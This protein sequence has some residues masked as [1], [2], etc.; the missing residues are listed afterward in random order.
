MEKG[1]DKVVW[2][3]FNDAPDQGVALKSKHDAHEL[4]QRLLDS[5]ESVLMYLFPRDPLE[6]QLGGVFVD[7]SKHSRI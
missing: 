2:L 5:L 7:R 1:S 6:V 3:D 4:K